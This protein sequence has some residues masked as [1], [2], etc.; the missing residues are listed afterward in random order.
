MATNPPTLVLKR[1]AVDFLRD[2]HGLTTGRALAAAMGVAPS[3]VSRTL[4]GRSELR[5]EFI[6]RLCHALRAPIETIVALDPPLP[7]RTKDAA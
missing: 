6:A 1:E 4:A 3:T 7:D 2:Y 5:S